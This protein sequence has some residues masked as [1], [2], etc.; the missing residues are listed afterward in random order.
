MIRAIARTLAV[1][2]ALGAAYAFAADAVTLSNLPADLG[3]ETGK[4]GPRAKR[5]ADVYRFLRVPEELEGLACVVVPRGEIKQ[6]GKGY[7]FNVDRGAF[8]YLFVHDLQG[9]AQ[10]VPH[11]KNTG[12]VAEWK[13]H[14]GN[15][16]D[17]VYVK[18]FAKGRVTIPPHND[19][20]PNGTRGIPHLAAVSPR[21]IDLRAPPSPFEKMQAIGKVAPRPSKAI[22]ASPLSVGFETLD[23]RM[24]QP[25]RTYEHLAKL[26]V[27]WARVQTGWARTETVKGRYDFAWLDGVVDSLRKIGIQP[28]FSISYGNRLY[29][30]EAPDKSAVGWVPIFDEEAKAGWVRYTRTIAR[31]YRDRVRHYEIWNEPNHSGAFWKP[32]KPNAEEYVELIRVTASV[33]REEVPEAVIVG[34]ALAGMPTRYLQQCLDAGMGGL[35]DKVSYHPYRPLPEGGGYAKTIAQWRK[36]LAKSNPKIRLWQGENGAPSQPRG[37]GAMANLA[38]TEERQAKWLCRRILT[39][40]SLG[41][42]LTSYFHTVDM[43]N[44]NWGAGG[45][46]KTN[47]KGLLH[48]TDYTPKMSYR[49]YQCLCALFDSETKLA[50]LKLRVERSVPPPEIPRPVHTAT[51]RRRGKAVVAYWLPT[52]LFRRFVPRRATITLA[53]EGALTQPVLIDPLT[54][55]VYP[56]AGAKQDGGSWT[57]PALPLLNHPLVITDRSIALPD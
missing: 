46:G 11:W 47:F 29:T 38:W 54:S 20:K 17:T 16:T 35:V 30:P 40:L 43:V 27:K 1:P 24:F 9:Y 41:V 26:G 36:L 25:E 44:Y 57:L 52:D 7:A 37:V 6:P 4:L 28:W 39:D 21:E 32:K 55:A 12:L 14:Q 45:T 50:L 49:A 10:P 18:E 22:E 51:F 42:E 31:R 53:E 56:V 5:C 33:I 34:G 8:V 15:H 48:G 13:G 2:I 3:A 19:R 23:R